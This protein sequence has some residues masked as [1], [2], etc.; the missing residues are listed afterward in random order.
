MLKNYLTQI[1]NVKLENI[2]IFTF[3]YSKMDEEIKNDR[4]KMLL[5]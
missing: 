2:S 3:V 1:E 5:K 4:A